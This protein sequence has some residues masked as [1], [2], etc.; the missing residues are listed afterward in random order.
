MTD[1][2]LRGKTGTATVEKRAVVMGLYRRLQKVR[3]NNMI[4]ATGGA[5]SKGGAVC[6]K[7]AWLKWKEVALTL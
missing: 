5:W 6:A 2:G 3:K 1:F 4:A 7:C